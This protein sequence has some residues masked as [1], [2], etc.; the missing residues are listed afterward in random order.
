MTPEDADSVCDT[1]KR[2]LS[3]LEKH[4]QAVDTVRGVWS[5]WLREQAPRVSEAVVARA[6]DQLVARGDLISQTVPGGEV[7]FKRRFH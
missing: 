1:A 3:Y 5:W 7:L 4:P 2:I 6:L